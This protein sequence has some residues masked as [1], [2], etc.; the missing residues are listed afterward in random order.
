MLGVTV[1][2]WSPAHAL[3]TSLRRATNIDNVMFSS[4]NHN[5]GPTRATDLLFLFA[6]FCRSDFVLIKLSIK[7]G[8]FSPPF[9]AF[10]AVPRGS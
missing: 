4:F 2:L 10:S 3:S 7:N 5:A 8:G 1:V 6:T 9:N